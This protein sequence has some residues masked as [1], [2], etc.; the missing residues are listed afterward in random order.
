MRFLLGRRLRVALAIAAALVVLAFT[1]PWG[2][3]IGCADR[4]TRSTCTSHVYTA[5]GTDAWSAAPAVLLAAVAASLV[6]VVVGI[7]QRRRRSA[8]E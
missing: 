6:W 3:V 5:A 8:T 2:G 4:M 1:A 7:V